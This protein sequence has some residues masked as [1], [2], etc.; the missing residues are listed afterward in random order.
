MAMI[1]TDR[2]RCIASE[3]LGHPGSTLAQAMAWF[4]DSLYLGAS[5]P[6][7]RSVEDRARIWRWSPATEEWELVHDSPVLPLDEEGRARAAWLGRGGGARRTAGIESFGRE[8]GIRSM[9]VFQ[10]PGDAAPCLYAGT[11]SIHGGLILRSEDGRH[12]EPVTDPG[13]GDDRVLSFLGLVAHEGRFFAA[14]AGTISATGIDRNM[15]PEAI[16]HVSRDPARGGFVPACAPSFGDPANRGIS[17]LVSANGRVH[18]GTSNP[19]RGF[20]LW[21]TDA[22]G[23]APFV[24]RRDLMD[25]AWRYNQNMQVSEMCGFGG[26]LY[27]GTGV[28]GLGLDADNDIGPCAAELIRVHPDGSWDLIFGEPRFTPDG[29]KVP[30]SGFGPGLGD[31][32][33]SAIWSMAVHEGVLYI[34]TQNWKSN[35]LAAHGAGATMS[36]GYQIWASADGETWTEVVADGFGNPGS[37]GMRRLISTPVGLFMGS[38]NHT[39]LVRTQARLHGGAMQETESPGGFEVLLG[40]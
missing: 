1:T 38:S 34:G 21:S 17:A 6:G 18:A 26:S 33:N 19:A 32:W 40:V 12:F 13:M 39:R 2:I 16:V 9:G 36:G 14:P 27:V 11:L 15:T 23:E 8:M 20:Q 35:D 10:E 24:W 25:G 5:A 22:T 30:L 31:P 7:S 4:Q 37:T 29:F 3:G 28:P